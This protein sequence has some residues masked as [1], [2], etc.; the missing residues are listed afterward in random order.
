L[1]GLLFESAWAKDRKDYAPHSSKHRFITDG[2]HRSPTS[3]INVQIYGGGSV[4]STKP[5]GP[6]A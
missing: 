2:D 1:R 5:F 4:A 6:H 3:T